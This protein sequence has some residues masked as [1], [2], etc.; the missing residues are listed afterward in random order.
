[1]AA[2]GCNDFLSLPFPQARRSTVEGHARGAK[3][4][5]P[6]PGTVCEIGVCM[7][8]LM[9]DLPQRLVEERLPPELG[10]QEHKM[11]EAV[12]RVAR[13]PQAGGSKVPGHRGSWG[14]YGPHSHSGCCWISW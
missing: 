1:M 12:D 11:L 8:P 10:G 13:L 3:G 2:A 14:R 9:M 7:T 4:N 6:L 5:Q